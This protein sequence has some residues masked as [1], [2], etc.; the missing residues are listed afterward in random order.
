MCGVL[1]GEYFSDH[2]PDITGKECSQHLR[3]KWL[4]EVAELRAYS[5]AAIDQFK[6]F[7]T[8]DTERYR[9]P[10]GRKEVHEPRQCVFIGTTNKDLYLQRRNRQSPLLAGQDRHH[11][12]RLPAT[13]SRS[14]LRRGGVPLRK[15]RAMVAGCRIRAR[16]DRRRTGSAFR[17]RRV[18]E[19]HSRLSRPPSR[20][21]PRCGRSVRRSSISRSARSATRT[22]GP[23]ART[24]RA[25]PRSTGS[26]SSTSTALPAS[27]PISDGSQSAISASD[28]G[29][30][31]TPSGDSGD[32]R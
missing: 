13:G 20:G 17:G 28:G 10:W 31:K 24:S 2:L 32:V 6:E 29:S 11:Q 12:A 4:I 27:S 15:G 8:R 9:P 5:R 23:P 30:R 19:A 14:A 21:R 26:P 1:A 3:G 7:L 25:A 22:G 16:D 18:G